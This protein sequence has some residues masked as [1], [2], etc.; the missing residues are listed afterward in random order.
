MA[1]QLKKHAKLAEFETDHLSMLLHELETARI[2]VSRAE[3][4]IR[5]YC[6]SLILRHRGDPKIHAIDQTLAFVIEVPAKKIAEAIKNAATQPQP[7]TQPE[8]TPATP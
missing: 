2:A 8:A 4:K 1:E 5:V 6:N 7:K 3:D